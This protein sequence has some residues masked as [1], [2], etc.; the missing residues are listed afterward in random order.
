MGHGYLLQAF[1]GW[2]GWAPLARLTYSAYLYHPV[3]QQV[4][5]SNF[6][7]MFHYDAWM[8]GTFGTAFITGSYVVALLSYLFVERPIMNF[9]GLI[10]P[11]HK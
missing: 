6:R 10:F 9:E 4:V 1:L 5:L 2:E 7:T 3:V 11:H 8:I